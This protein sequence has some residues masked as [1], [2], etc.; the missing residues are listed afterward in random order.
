MQ[1]AALTIAFV[2]LL[3]YLISRFISKKIVSYMVIAIA[4]IAVFGALTHPGEVISW[5]GNVIDRMW[6]VVYESARK[7]TDAFI[8]LISNLVRGR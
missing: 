4:A 1:D 6:P 2:L 3:L 7:A 8:T 5:A